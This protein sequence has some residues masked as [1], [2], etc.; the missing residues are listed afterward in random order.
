LLFVA[1]TVASGVF[2]NARHSALSVFLS[3]SVI[4]F[5]TILVICLIVLVPVQRWTSLGVMIASCGIFG[6]GYYCFAWR[7]MVREGMTRLVDL[8]DRV[9]YGVLPVV[10]YLFETAS[11]VTLAL[12]LSVGCE[13]L[14][15]S[16]GMVLV[17][18]IHNA[19]D[20]TV[21]TITRPQDGNASS[22][23]ETQEPGTPTGST[24]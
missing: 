7:N 22:A 16:M 8:E 10:G 1:A 6:I 18:G 21:W 4:H 3:A 9:W 19:W 20:I 12:R 2:T 13:A 11:G 5:S 24:T 14:A 17:V 15:L 23:Q